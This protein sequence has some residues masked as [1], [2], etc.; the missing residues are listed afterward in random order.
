MCPLRDAECAPG[1]LPI[2]QIQPGRV[3]SLRYVVRAPEQP[4]GGQ[5]PLI[6]AHPLPPDT[7]IALEKDMAIELRGDAASG[8]NEDGSTWCA[9]AQPQRMLTLLAHSHTLIPQV[10]QER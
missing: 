3:P 10:A 9:Q 5:T 7:G 1:D 6:C 8:V 2:A 4:R